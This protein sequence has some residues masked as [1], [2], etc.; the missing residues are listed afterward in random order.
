MIERYRKTVFL[1]SVLFIAW[2]GRSLTWNF[3]PIYFKTVL[4]SPTAVGFLTS[5]PALTALLIDLPIGN[6]IQRTGER[7]FI[8][9]GLI[10]PAAAAASYTLASTA[11]FLIG[12]TVEGLS[13]SILWTGSWSLS[14]KASQDDSES[15]SISLMLLGP[16]L[17]AVAAPPI[18][19]LILASTGF[20]VLFVAWIAA[21]LI[22]GAAFYRYSKSFERPG[23]P[24]NI[25]KASVFREDAAEVSRHWDVLKHS[26]GLMFLVSVL[27]SFNWLAVPLFLEGNGASYLEMGLIFGAAFT[28]NLLMF[29]FGKIADTAGRLKSLT[30]LF[31][32]LAAALTALGLQDSVP[33]IGLTYF[34][35]AAFTYGMKPIVH[36]LFDLNVPDE[37]EGELTGVLE[38]VKHFGEFLGPLA[39]G[40]I[41]GF[42]SLETVFLTAAA[43]SLGSG[44]YSA[45]ILKKGLLKV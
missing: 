3:L 18:G 34:F 37:K 39:A 41:S 30:G 21:A 7:F 38:V 32:V 4:N 26:L 1:A 11:G 45:Y 31:I 12:K 16:N 42:F 43:L 28:P 5:L 40:L 23:D 2:F 20:N 27:V 14:M 9:T 19:G 13:K 25:L 29:G 24:R 44:L 33:L 36:T 8:A 22:A 10:I 35:S 15:R 6:Y 17:A